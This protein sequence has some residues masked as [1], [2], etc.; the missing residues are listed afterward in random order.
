MKSVFKIVVLGVF[1]FSFAVAAA[2]D[3][4]MEHVNGNAM[5]L[6]SAFS[7]HGVDYGNMCEY[8]HHTAM[9]VK[10]CGQ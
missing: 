10:L 8:S 4:F 3:P 5:V 9:M 2:N 6:S 1:A 7:V